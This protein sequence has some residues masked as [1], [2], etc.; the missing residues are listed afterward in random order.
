MDTRQLINNI[1]L[2]LTSCEKCGRDNFTAAP[3]MN[4]NEV[5]LLVIETERLLDFIEKQEK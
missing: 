5:R 1:K 4:I 3:W 2:Q